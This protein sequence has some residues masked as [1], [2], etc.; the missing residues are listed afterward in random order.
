[1]K[2]LIVLRH[3]HA[4]DDG[5]H[6]LEAMDPFLP[7]GAL[8]TDVEQSKR[9][10]IKE[11]ESKWRQNLTSRL[12]RSIISATHLKLRFLKE[13]W[14]STMPVVLTRVRRISCSVGW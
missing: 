5:R 13:K 10:K 8:A 3:G 6:V 9:I 4:K 14:T 12:F 2:H 7:L 1:V 11:N